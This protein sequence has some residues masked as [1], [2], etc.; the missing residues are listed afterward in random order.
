MPKRQKHTPPFSLSKAFGFTDHTLQE[1]LYR[2]PMVH[3]NCNGALVIENY[4]QI[5][6]YQPEQIRLD[7]GKIVLQIEGDALVMDTLQKTCITV[8]GN[9]FAVRFLYE[10]VR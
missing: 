1:A 6:T 4:K 5:I 9:L 8:H 7:M 2:Q 10:E 3:L